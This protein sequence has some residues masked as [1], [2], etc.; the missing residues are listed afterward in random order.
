MGWG[1][2]WIYSGGKTSEISTSSVDRHL[3]MNP[4]YA[5]FYLCDLGQVSLSEPVVSHLQNGDDTYL[6]GL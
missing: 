1:K 5:S 6:A 4:G 2:G 3:G